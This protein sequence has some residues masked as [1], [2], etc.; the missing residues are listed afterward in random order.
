MGFISAFDTGVRVSLS[1]RAWQCGGAVRIV[2]CSRVAVRD[3][4]Q[5][6]RVS[7]A[8]DFRHIV[9]LSFD[10]DLRRVAYRSAIHDA[11]THARTYS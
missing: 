1:C 8:R 2:T 4:Q 10:D 5:A 7:D 11:R 3:T 9:E 6:V